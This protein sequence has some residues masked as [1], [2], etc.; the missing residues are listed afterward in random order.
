MDWT[1]ID[2]YWDWT[3]MDDTDQTN[4]NPWQMY[5]ITSW[6]R[7]TRLYKEWEE[8]YQLFTA[9]IIKWKFRHM[10][11]EKT[12]DNKTKKLTIKSNIRPMLLNYLRDLSRRLFEFEKLLEM[13][14]DNIPHPR[15]GY[16]FFAAGCRNHN[17][18]VNILNLIDQWKEMAKRTDLMLFT[19]EED[20]FLEDTIEGALLIAHKWRRDQEERKG[21]AASKTDNVVNAYFVVENTN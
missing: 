10:F 21:E 19:Q 17:I 7:A 18:P 16:D 4:L 20:L 8:D 1:D 14:K 15:R 6:M 5:M 12:Y 13:L 2:L 9:T 11:Y 3:E